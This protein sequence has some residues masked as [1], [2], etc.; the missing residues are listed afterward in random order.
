M[1][2]IINF[3]ISSNEQ[4]C[5]S[6]SFHKIN[7]EVTK[8]FICAQKHNKCAETALTGAKSIALKSVSMFSPGF[9]GLPQISNFGISQMNIHCPSGINSSN[10]NV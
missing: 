8:Y 5:S 6:I 10:V 3:P 2:L 9:S 7:I 4:V 1:T